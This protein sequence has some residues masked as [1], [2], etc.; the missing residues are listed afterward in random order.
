MMPAAIASWFSGDAWVQ[1]LA[2]AAWEV[3]DLKPLLAVLYAMACFTYHG[4]PPPQSSGLA[5]VCWGAVNSTAPL[6][7]L[8]V[9]M[10]LLLV[11]SMLQLKQQSMLTVRIIIAL[12][13]CTTVHGWCTS[14]SKTS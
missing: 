5:R 10:L 11:A 12:L 8:S 13:P 9:L 14:I 2:L 6:L 7:G 3:A 1:V 4:S